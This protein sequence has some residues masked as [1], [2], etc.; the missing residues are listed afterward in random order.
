[1][2]FNRSHNGF[3]GSLWYL[4]TIQHGNE[5][6]PSI[7]SIFPLERP[8]TFIYGRCPT[9]MFGDRHWV[10]VFNCNGPKLGKNLERL[11]NY[12]EIPWRIL[13]VIGSKWVSPHTVA[14]IYVCLFSGFGITRFFRERQIHPMIWLESSKHYAQIIT[15]IVMIIM[16]IMIIIY[17]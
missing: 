9:T 17:I 3:I 14:S 7:D 10:F 2:H 11:G 5:N 8:M 4:P 6:H 16:M 13:A 15:I 12:W 1:M